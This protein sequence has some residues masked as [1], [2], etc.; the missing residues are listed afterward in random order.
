MWENLLYIYI[1][2]YICESLKSVLN[3]GAKTGRIYVTSPVGRDFNKKHHLIL[4]L[5][6]F[7]GTGQIR[8]D[9]RV[10][11]VNSWSISG[12][13]REA[14]CVYVRGAWMWTSRQ[15]L[16]FHLYVF[17]V[18]LTMY[19]IV[20]V[21]SCFYVMSFIKTSLCHS[22]SYS[23]RGTFS[24][25]A[26]SVQTGVRPLTC[27]SPVYGPFRGIYWHSPGLFNSLG[28]RL[29]PSH[30]K[31]THL[32]RAPLATLHLWSSPQAPPVHCSLR[33]LLTLLL[34]AD[35]RLCYLFQFACLGLAKST[36]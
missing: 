15:S 31:Q 27:T 22:V 30:T 32:C 33:P 35:V 3:I 5:C 8:S 4:S 28:Q 21:S 26:S 24:I 23:R 25:T 10:G 7:K 20:A 17:L 6:S 2:I 29:A 13:K 19:V 12:R 36:I 18:L 9:Q 11:N 16:N 1:Y 14:S 34:L